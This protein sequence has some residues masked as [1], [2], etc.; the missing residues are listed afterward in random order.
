MPRDS[1]ADYQY[2][3]RGILRKM[4]ANGRCTVVS[5]QEEIPVGTLSQY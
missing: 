3:I 4:S 1:I 2:F 5:G